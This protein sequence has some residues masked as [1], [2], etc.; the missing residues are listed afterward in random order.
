MCVA[1][2]SPPALTASRNSGK[3]TAGTIIAGWRSVRTTERAPAR[4]AGRPWLT[5]RAVHAGTGS[6]RRRSSRFVAGAL[7]ASGRS[8]RG[9]RRRG[10]GS[11]SWRWATGALGVERAHDVGEVVAVARSARR[12]P[13]ARRGTRLAEAREHRRRARSR[14]SPGRPGTTST[15]GRPISAFSSAGRALG[16]DLAVVDDPD[17]VGEH[18]GL[19]EVLGGEEDRHAVLARRGGATSS[20]SAVRLWRSRPVVGSSR[21]RIRGP[22]HEREREVEAALHAARVAA[23]A[24]SAASVRPTRSSSSSPRRAALGLRQPCSAGLQAH[25]L[26]AGEERVERGLLQRGADRARA[27]AGPR[28]TT[29]WPPTRAV[30]GGRRQQRGQH[31]ARSSTCRRRWGRGSRRSRRARRRG[32]CRRPRAGPS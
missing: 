7:E 29:S 25:V 32:R 11:W 21:N 18:V 27:P 9:R 17:A 1:A 14:S 2:S 16:D 3:T 20:H 8:W 15:V 13:W 6:D 28:A 12:R 23:D 22:V 19:L 26:A 10:V 24:R 4:R 31:A 30:P 5:R